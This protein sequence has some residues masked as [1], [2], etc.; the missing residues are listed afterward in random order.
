MA[1][2]FGQRTFLR[3]F[4]RRGSSSVTGAASH[5][6]GQ[7]AGWRLLML[8]HPIGSMVTKVHHAAVARITAGRW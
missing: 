2:H 4:R 1:W 7:H 5:R 8:L 6:G 3:P